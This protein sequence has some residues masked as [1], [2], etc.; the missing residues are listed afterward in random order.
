MPDAD[1]TVF[2]GRDPA[3]FLRDYWQKVRGA[4][5]DME[6]PLSPEELAGLAL[7]EEVRSRIVQVS[8]GAYP[9]QLRHGPFEV[10]DFTSLPD[11][12]WTLLVQEVDQ[13]NPSAAALLDQFRFIPNWRIDDLM[14]SYAAPSGGV[15]AHIDNYDVFLIQAMGQREWRIGSKPIA[16]ERLVPDLDVRILSDFE[17]AERWILEPGDM[18]YLPPR[19][20][21]EGVALE[22][23]MTLSVGF[24]APSYLEMIDGFATYLTGVVDER[25]RYEDPDLEPTTDPGR[26]ADEVVEELHRSLL[27][28]FGDRQAFSAWL[29]SYLT[30]PRRG[31]PTLPAGED[32]SASDVRASI[33]AGKRLVRPTLGQFAYIQRPDESVSLFASGEEIHL[34]EQMAFAAALLSSPEPLSAETLSAHL[35]NHQ[36]LQLFA[37]LVNAGLLFISENQDGA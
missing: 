11:E 30:E 7:E 19:I 32:L 4:F 29:G 15:G 37:D 14:V 20:A 34:R 25:R 33:Q 16:V 21:H 6:P 27:S 8:G 5:A 31:K 23:C 9:W 36:L 1:A 13:W 18:L 2:G 26:I 35:E 17:P 24:R 10:D 12:G 28:F 22:A 3:A